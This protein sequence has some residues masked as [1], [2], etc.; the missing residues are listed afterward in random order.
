M[1]RL[2]EQKK[3][4]LAALLAAAQGV[5]L[6]QDRLIVMLGHGTAFARS[7]LDDPEH[8]RLVAGAAA[9]VFG[10][11]LTVEYRFQTSD[12]VPA[13]SDSAGTTTGGAAK[14]A[15]GQGQKKIG[16]R[17]EGVGYGGALPQPPAPSPQPSTAEALRRHPLVGRAVELFDG[18]VVRI[19]T[20]QPE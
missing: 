14:R 3:R 5:A 6:E 16:S 10:R 1:T 18:Q 9:E 13:G 17:G 20:K 2:L 19:R 12:I 4:S 15:T 8:R 7:T 11:P